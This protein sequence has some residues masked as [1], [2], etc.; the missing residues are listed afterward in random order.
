MEFQIYQSKN[1]N[2]YYWRLQKGEDTIATGHQGYDT[3]Q[4]CRND[5]EIVKQSANVP[6]V[7]Y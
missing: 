5:I 3:E 7:V 1:D 2:R 4:Q 6:I